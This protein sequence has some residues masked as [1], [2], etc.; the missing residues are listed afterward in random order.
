ML[1]EEYVALFKP[2]GFLDSKSMTLYIFSEF[3]AFGIL[4]SVISV[5]NN[6]Y[7]KLFDD[8]IQCYIISVNM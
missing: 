4:S 3:H 8:F 2:L 1:H 7:G 5:E 6:D